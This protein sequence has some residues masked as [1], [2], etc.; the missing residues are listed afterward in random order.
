[1]D[2]KI[3]FLYKKNPVLLRD[4]ILTKNVVC[5]ITFYR[6]T[7]TLLFSRITVTLT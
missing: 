7:L 6:A 1:M 4:G 3:Q 2:I 5:R